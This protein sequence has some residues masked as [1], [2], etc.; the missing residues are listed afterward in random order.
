[1]A[2]TGTWN[3]RILLLRTAA[4]M[5]ILGVAVAVGGVT[6]GLWYPLGTAAC[7]LTLAVLAFRKHRQLSLAGGEV[8]AVRRGRWAAPDSSCSGC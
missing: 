3:F 2:Y 6:A 7:W 8:H 4:L 5:A 1:V